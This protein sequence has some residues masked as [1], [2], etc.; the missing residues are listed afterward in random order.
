MI[1][2]D[3]PIR[4]AKRRIPIQDPLDPAEAWIEQYVLEYFGANGWEAIP[5]VD[6]TEEGER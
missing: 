2:R 6:A 1:E 4:W 5:H 3:M